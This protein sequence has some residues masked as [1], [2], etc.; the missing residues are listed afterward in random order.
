MKERLN[1]ATPPWNPPYF[2]GFPP[3]FLIFFAPD[4]PF[5]NT[6]LGK[7]G[8]RNYRTQKEETRNTTER[9]GT[10]KFSQPALES[11][12]FRRIPPRFP[13]IF[14]HA[15]P[16]TQHLIGKGGKYETTADIRQTAGPRGTLRSQTERL[17]L[18][19]PPWNPPYLG[20]FLPN[21]QIF[22]APGPPFPTPNWERWEMRHYRRPKTKRGN[23]RNATEHDGTPKFGQSP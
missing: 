13:D 23:P 14:A 17:N 5:T 19:N 1:L 15:H 4:T 8:M 9:D 20:G 18:A 12:I 22:F 11:T 3:N 21:S 6:P 10:P 7:G 2:G 16:I